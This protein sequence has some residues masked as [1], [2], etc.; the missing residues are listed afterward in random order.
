MPFLAS[1]LHKV[2]TALGR[3]ERTPEVSSTAALS[4][5]SGRT[6]PIIHVFVIAALLPHWSPAKA[7]TVLLQTASKSLFRTDVVLN[8]KLLVRGLI[9]TGSS[10]LGICASMAESL[11][12]ILGPPIGLQTANGNLIAHRARLQS[13]RIGRVTLR[14]VDAVVHPANSSC[15]EAL[16]GMSFLRRLRALV[17]RGDTLQ[18]VGK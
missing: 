10:S 4:Q 3:S 7:E 18:L 12:I 1:Q 2:A 11:G 15:Q 16:I 9:D 5:P 13:V 17:I 6:A 8:E 14:E